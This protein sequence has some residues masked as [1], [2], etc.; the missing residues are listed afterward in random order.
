MADLTELEQRLEALKAQAHSPVARVS[1]E[2]RTVEY[3]GHAEI[4]SAIADL[5]RQIN[6]AQGNKPV[7]QIRVHTSKGY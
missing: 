5:E 7:R 2:G 4:Q 1:Y 6:T 3:R